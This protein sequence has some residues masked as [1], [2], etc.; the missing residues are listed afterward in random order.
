[1]NTARESSLVY[2]W[3]L[4]VSQAL[5]VMCIILLMGVSS[6]MG[7]AC[8]RSRTHRGEAAGGDSEGPMQGLGWLK[9]KVSE[10]DSG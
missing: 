9:A 4:W 5:A 7:T 3:D 6:P 1:M 8:T 2:P 10:F